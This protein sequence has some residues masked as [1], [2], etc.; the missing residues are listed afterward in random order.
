MWPNGTK[1]DGPFVNGEMH[2][3]GIFT[4]TNGMDSESDWVGGR[5]LNM[6]A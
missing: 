2:G 5:R 4:D 6:F 3:K 1:Y